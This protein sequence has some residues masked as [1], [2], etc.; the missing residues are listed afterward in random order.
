M[1]KKK[2]TIFTT[3][4]CVALLAVCAALYLSEDRQGPE[5]RLPQT[6]VS[7]AQGDDTEILLTDVTAVDAR[8]GDVTDTLRVAQV[9]DMSNLNYVVVTY[10]ARDHSNNVTKT[11]RW[12]NLTDGS[13]SEAPSEN[14]AAELED[15]SEAAIAQ[16]LSNTD[17]EENTETEASSEAAETDVGNDSAQTGT[18]TE[19]T[20]AASSE[21]GSAEESTPESQSEGIQTEQSEELVSTG[22]PVIRITTHELHLEVGQSFDYMSYVQACVDDQDTM[23]ELYSRIVVNGEDE[24]GNFVG[25]GIIDT[26]RVS[27]YNLQFYVF[28]TDG[29]MSNVENMHVTVGN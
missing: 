9:T 22:A 14:L 12:I 11:D 21:T 19:N 29:N 20:A 26:S 8:D 23:D 3:L 16:I 17:T 6:S 1:S 7:Y 2:L 13:T 10:V 28:D 15:Q 4:L 18:G 5:I 27:S 24:N 25:S